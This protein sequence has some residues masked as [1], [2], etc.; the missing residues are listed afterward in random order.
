M[1]SAAL[2]LMRSILRRRCRRSRRRRSP[3]TADRQALLAD[4]GSAGNAASAAYLGLRAVVVAT[5]FD[6][7]A[8]QDATALQAQYRADHFAFGETEYDWALKHN[9]KLQTSARELFSGMAHRRG[10]A[11]IHG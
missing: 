1:G 11:R 5:F 2:L 4:L 10:H 9:F 7:S 8:A 6:N 3:E